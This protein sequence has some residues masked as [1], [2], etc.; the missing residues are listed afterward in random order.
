MMNDRVVEY[1]RFNQLTSSEL[2]SLDLDY[3]KNNPPKNNP[4]LRDLED[5][6]NKRNQDGICESSCLL[7]G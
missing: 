4:S 5:Y 7:L 3:R 2:N 6:Y 1:K